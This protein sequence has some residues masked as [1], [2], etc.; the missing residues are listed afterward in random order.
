MNTRLFAFIRCLFVA[1]LLVVR[2]DAAAL[3][4]MDLVTDGSANP[5]GDRIDLEVYFAPNERG[6]RLEVRAYLVSGRSN[7]RI[8][9]VP[10]RRARGHFLLVTNIV[11]HRDEKIGSYAIVVSYADL[12]IRHGQFNIGYELRGL[13]GGVLQFAQATRLTKVTISENPRRQMRVTT[14]VERS[15]PVVVTNTTFALRDNKPVEVTVKQTQRV[16]QGSHSTKVIPVNIPNAYERSEVVS[17]SAMRE[18]HSLASERRSYK[19][20]PWRPEE[21][22]LIQFFSN[23]GVR[24]D[25]ELGFT[26]DDSLS[27]TLIFGIANVNIPIE[28]HQMG[29][30]ELRSWW[31]IPDDDRF[32]SIYSMK[33]MSRQAFLKSNA[34]ALR[35]DKRDVLIYVHG[36]N[37][38]FEFA[39]LRLAQF[40]HDIQFPGSPILFSWP[41]QGSV[42]NY[43]TDETMADASIPRLAEVLK[44]LVLERQSDS[45]KIHLLAHSLGSRVLLHAIHKV[46]LDVVPKDRPFGQIILAAPDMDSNEFNNMIPSA[47]RHADAVNLYFCKDDKALMASRVFHLDSRV[48]QIGFCRAEIANIDALN[49]NTSWLSHDYFTTRH[50]LLHDL[51]LV[52]LESLKAAQRATIHPIEAPSPYCD[53]FGFR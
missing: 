50:V 14:D 53:Y 25:R 51:K 46:V 41:S 3:R 47:F 7:E 45:A 24:I 16:K 34:R 28:T 37:N 5:P 2:L 13:K 39:T 20:R 11:R 43:Q 8:T 44:T 49:A 27:P 1:A 12:S 4:Q 26:L 35:V 10:G 30:L 9:P 23:R 18:A 32:F 42:R 15:V 21:K 6:L 48:G 36:F 52:V 22:K 33:D 31:Q 40:V 38:T 17:A 29:K 19:S